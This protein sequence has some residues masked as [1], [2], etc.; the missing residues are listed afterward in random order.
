MLMHSIFGKIIVWFL[1]TFAL[2]LAAFAFINRRIE[3]RGPHPRDPFPHM[4]EMVQRDA[5]HAYHEGGQPALREFLD[6][7]RVNLPGEHVFVD[8]TGHDLVSGADRCELLRANKPP[9]PPSTLPDGRVVFRGPM[10]DPRYQFFTLVRPW[11]KP[12]DFLPYFAVIVAGIAV[13]AAILAV[14]LASPLRHLK[15]IV[16]RFG[17]GDL[18]AR[19]GSHRGDEIGQLARSFDEMA[20]RITTLLAAERQLLQDVSHELRSPL[21]RLGFAVQ[22]ARSGPDPTAA[23]RRI[24]T[25]VNRLGKLVQELLE[26]T[27]IEGEPRLRGTELLSLGDLL[28]SIVDDCQ[29]EAESH[30]CSLRLAMGDTQA[31]IAGSAELV[32]RAVENAVRNAVRYTPRGST[33]DVGLSGTSDHII[34]T[35]RDYGVGV[36]PELLE[37]IFEP[38]R[39]VEG[40]RSRST[41]GVGL[42]LAIARRAV[43]LHGGTMTAANASPG[44][45]V[46]ITLPRTTS[47]RVVT[48]P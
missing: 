32:R 9:M 47:L 40:D 41:G 29:L 2:S 22:L 42:G 8:G 44:L 5:L 19:A 16:E 36:S 38:F 37:A 18:T 20:D 23:L 35:I 31:T 4:L 12:P 13:M 17:S 21:A 27:R 43:E 30:G 25:D 39:R 6:R 26:L 45:L 28:Q 48:K 7:L 33:I 10:L 46:T 3:P 15:A 34:I 1:L 24:E 14:H 11:F